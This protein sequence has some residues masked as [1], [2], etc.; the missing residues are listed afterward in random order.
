MCELEVC[1]DEQNRVAFLKFSESSV[2]GSVQRR[3]GNGSPRAQVGAQQSGCNDWGA[4]EWL[5]K[6][7]RRSSILNA[8]SE[9]DLRQ[10]PLQVEET[11]SNL[12]AQ[13][14]SIVFYS[15]SIL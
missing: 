8:S 12:G 3:S 2:E 13:C 5:V 11:P 10:V 7:S 14:F 4:W 15:I 1:S 9:L 6:V